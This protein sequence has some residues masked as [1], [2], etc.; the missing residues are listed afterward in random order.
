MEDVLDL[1]ARPH[2]PHRPLVCFDESNKE[3]H[4][5]VVEPVPVAPGHAARHERTYERNGVSCLCS[6]RPWKTGAT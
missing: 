3:Q 1:Y 2:D 5:E 4:R 6:S